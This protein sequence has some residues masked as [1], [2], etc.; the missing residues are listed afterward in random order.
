MNPEDIEAVLLLPRLKIQNANCVSS[1]LT[2]GFPPPSAFT[3]FGHLLERKLRDQDRNLRVLGVGI[4]CHGF[5]AQVFQPPGKRT[6]VFRLTRNPVDHTG[7]SA[8]LVEEGRAHF[9]ASLLLAISGPGCP[10]REIEQAEL[11]AEALRLAEGLRLAGGSVLPH[12]QRD[13]H[14]PRW[15]EWPEDHD[16]QASAFRK[17]RRRLLPGFALVSRADLLAA[18]LAELQAQAPGTAPDALDALLDLCSLTIGPVADPDTG[19]TE[20]RARRARDGWLVPLPVGYAAISPLYE[21][22]QV[23]NARD[24]AVPFRFVESVLS[25]GQWIG[26]HRIQL[27][28]HLLWEHEAQPEAGLYRLH[29]AYCPPSNAVA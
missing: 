4:V 18:H 25:L 28:H 9:E 3:G 29:N 22:G 19:K 13:R 16:S 12:P 6:Q 15:L 14:P 21:P 24:P 8:A 1:P 7:T 10:S 23:R 17:L 5:E 27:M 2:W 26:P 20:W 11:A